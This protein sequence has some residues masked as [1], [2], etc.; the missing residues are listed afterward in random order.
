[1]RKGPRLVTKVWTFVYSL[2]C[3]IKQQLFFLYLSC[4][5]FSA[6]WGQALLGTNVCF[7]F[8]KCSG[9]VAFRG[10]RKRPGSASGAHE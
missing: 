6:F 10:L 7:I 8:R 4:V 2:S 1:M 5:P 3:C 9:I